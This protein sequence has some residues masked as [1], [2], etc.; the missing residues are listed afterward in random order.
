[1]YIDHGDGWEAGVF[2]K[3]NTT[4]AQLG[5]TRRF[6]I[7]L[8]FDDLPYDALDI[9]GRTL[10]GAKEDGSVDGGEFV[11][12]ILY[13]DDGLSEC[14]DFCDLAVDSDFGVGKNCG[15]HLHC[16]VPD[17]G[18]GSFKRVALAYHYTYDFW[19]G[20]SDINDNRDTYCEEHQWNPTDLADSGETQETV[21][22][23]STRYS[24]YAWFNVASYNRFGTVEVRVHE[25]TRE[26]TDV[27]N[28]VIAHA[29]FIDAVSDLTVGQITRLFSNR[30]K[31]STKFK[32]IRI[33]LGNPEVSE[34]LQRRYELHHGT[35]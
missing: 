22:R 21:K 18:V 16:E 2:D 32:E 1:M 8:E 26:K 7:E 6:G 3:P 31:T 29:R 11:S 33:M 25:G 17:A 9:N 10:F 35:A 14:E 5:S 30:K 24:R 12:P 27:V 19:K 4:Y 28:W 13:G 15:F 23:W 20:T 34:H